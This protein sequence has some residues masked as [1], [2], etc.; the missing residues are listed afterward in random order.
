MTL[1]TQTDSEVS[2]VM[3]PVTKSAVDQPSNDVSIKKPSTK[4]KHQSDDNVGE[5]CKKVSKS[6]KR[7]HPSL[8]FD[9]IDHFPRIDKSRLVRCKNESC[10]KKTYVIC[11]KCNVHL[12]FNVVEER[13]CFTDFH[14]I[15]K[16]NDANTANQ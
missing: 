9:K 7:P 15:E 3:N 13:N 6:E 10:D 16:E 5:S 4:R 8:R 1:H 14:V 12:C 11:P 2:S